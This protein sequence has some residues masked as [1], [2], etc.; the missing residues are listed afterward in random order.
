MSIISQIHSQ[1]E[2]FLHIKLKILAQQGQD[3]T[4]A[5][6]DLEKMKIQAEKE[7]ARYE[8]ESQRILQNEGRM[9][10][11]NPFSTLWDALFGN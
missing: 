3:T 5:T 9:A 8:V 11:D 4:K 1:I 2:L 6:L 10:G 7:L